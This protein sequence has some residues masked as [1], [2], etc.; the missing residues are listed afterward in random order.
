MSGHAALALAALVI[1]VLLLSAS[2][3]YRLP[4]EMWAVS[5]GFGLGS[6]LLPSVWPHYRDDHWD[7]TSLV[8]LS[9]CAFAANMY[10]SRTRVAQLSL[11]WRAYVDDE[12]SNL[13]HLE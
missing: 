6:V 5:S 13:P 1:G 12:V 11:A 2:L 7:L 8:A 10:A 3:R 9:A 4:Q